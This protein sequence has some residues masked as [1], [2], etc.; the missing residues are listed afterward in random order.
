VRHFPW[1]SST[2]YGI[3]LLAGLYYPLAGV[4]DENPARLTG[5]VA[6][7]VALFAVE[8]TERRRDRAPALYL[9]TRLA[10]FTTAA[11]LDE[12]G[13][14]RALF[15]LVPFT[16]YLTFG[17]RTGLTLGALSLTL[18]VTGYAV[19]VPNWYREATYLS[20]LLM[21]GMGLILALAMA[22]VATREQ[23]AAARI[24]ALTAVSERNRM[25]RD[26]HDSLGHHLT[27]IAIQLE[28]AQA[29]GERDPAAA[30]QALTDA[31]DST[32]RALRDVRT[33]VGTLRAAPITLR[34]AL[35][36]LATT[37]V[38][39]H[40]TG[41]D[42][43]VDPAMVTTLQR[44][45][46]EAITNAGRHGKATKIAV[47]AT[48]TA[49]GT[50][51]VVADNGKGFNPATSTPGFGLKGLQERTELAGGN[52][53]VESSPGKGTRITISVPSKGS[54]TTP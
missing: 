30:E 32:Q 8:A 37:Q 3:V 22:E 14:S 21:F 48:T 13:L 36:E 18:L 44:A 23:K 47:T 54:V 24:A 50:H 49:T 35:M 39:V 52:C 19:W 6:C 38:T 46:Q 9:A 2:I 20:D 34:A 10:L 31:R 43:N 17:R 25:A 33:S 45:A 4:G 7:M 27:A 26:I 41:E 16:A 28:K 53:T 5:F 42:D 15:V 11:A 29:F 12:S 1:V 40:I 51:L